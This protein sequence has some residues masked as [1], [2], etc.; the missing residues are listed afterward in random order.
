[1]EEPMGSSFLASMLPII[2]LTIPFAFG[3]YYLAKALRKPVPIWVILSL[4]PLVNY[5]FYIY[6]IY[7]VV[8]Q[9]IRRLEQIASAIN[10]PV[11]ETS[12]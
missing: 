12:Q 10:V 3:N 2:L 1:M 8:L 7:V 11:G 5:L 4:I 9:V 6:V